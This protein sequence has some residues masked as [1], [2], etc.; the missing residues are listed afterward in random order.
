MK[1]LIKEFTTIPQAVKRN[2]F[3]AV[4]TIISVVIV[5]TIVFGGLALIAPDLLT[6]H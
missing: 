2:Q 3:T 5:A 4:Q 6:K 1:K